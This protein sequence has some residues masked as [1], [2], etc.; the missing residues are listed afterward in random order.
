MRCDEFLRLLDGDSGGDGAEAQEHLAACPQCAHAHGR[1]RAVRTALAEMGREEAPPF[2]HQRVMASLRAD[3][4]RERRRAWWSAPWRAAWAG[5]ALVLAFVIAMGGYGLWRTLTPRGEGVADVQLVST[6]PEQGKDERHEKPAVALPR[7]EVAATP[8]AERRDRA[9]TRN[10]PEPKGKLQAKAR[11]AKEV[12]PAAPPRLETVAEV[13]FAPEPPPP[14]EAADRDVGAAPPAPAAADRE[15][16]AASSPPVAA[17]AQASDKAGARAGSTF[18]LQAQS[19]A[20]LQ[21][22][23]CVLRGV[24]RQRVLIELPEREAPAAGATWTVTVA[25]DGSL[26][27]RDGR[28]DDITAT[29]PETAAA[30]TTVRLSP[31]RYL[32]KRQ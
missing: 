14:G 13:A 11:A 9:D 10:A 1:W 16:A 23:R 28:D 6:Q 24:P 18:A 8:P 4:Q 2:L 21:A 32:L 19:K 3:V 25:A 12:T 7:A 26:E 20:M 31:G 29:C 27:L 30:I 22:V 17:E 5:P 15:V